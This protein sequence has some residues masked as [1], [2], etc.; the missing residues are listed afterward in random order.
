MKPEV[1]RSQ[2]MPA[3]PGESARAVRAGDTVW[4]SAQMDWRGKGVA[5][6]AGHV[7]RQ[8][9]ALLRGAG[10]GLDRALKARVCLRDMAD[11]PTFERIWLGS[12]PVPPPC[13]VAQP[14]P[15]G[16][17]V[18]AARLQ[19]DLT[20]A[21]G[22]T[23]QRLA[24]AGA[25][26]GADG[27]RLA[28]HG[29]H[30]YISGLVAGERST[31]IAPEAAVDPRFPYHGNAVEQQAAWVLKRLEDALAQAGSDLDHVVHALV[32]LTEATDFAAFDGVWKRWLRRFPP[33]ATVQ[34]ARLPV[35]G[36]V[37]QVDVTAVRTGTSISVIDSPDLP[38]PGANYSPAVQAGGLIYTAGYLA[39]D[40]VNGVAPE[41]RVRANFPFHGSAVQTQTRYILGNLLQLLAAGG[42]GSEQVVRGQV[43]LTDLRHHHAFRQVWDECFPHAPAL[44]VVE[45]AGDGL[46]VP[47]SLVEIELV[48]IPR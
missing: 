10:S 11:L 31:G 46:L 34:V 19:V 7:L 44:T 21:A 29:D 38:A 24:P 45:T 1:I 43:F 22:G 9:E 41:A 5:D 33:R 28:V 42:S 13:S 18:P 8:V 25:V 32:Y 36:A 35:P 40:F 26:A 16:L 12:F 2:Q 23:V 48:A 14:G 3:P 27:I 20:A 37:V 4:V 47:G 30:V 15:R 17:T 39:S 6:Q